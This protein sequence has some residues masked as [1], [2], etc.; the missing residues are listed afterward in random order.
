LRRRVDERHALDVVAEQL[1]ARDAFVLGREDVDDAAADRERSRFGGDVLSEVSELDQTHR[2]LVS[3]DRSAGSKVERLEIGGAR[4]GFVHERSRRRDDDAGAGPVSEQAQRLQAMCGH[5]GVGRQTLVGKDVPRRQQRGR[6]DEL[7]GR[8]PQRLRVGFRGHNDED[9]TLE[10][11]R[12]PGT[13]ERARGVGDGEPVAA[14]VCG[15]AEGRVGVP[16][17][18]EVCQR[19]SHDAP[20]RSGDRAEGAGHE[21]LPQLATALRPRT[22]LSMSRPNAR[23]GPVRKPGPCCCETSLCAFGRGAVSGGGLR[24]RVQPVLR[25][26]DAVGDEGADALQAALH[27]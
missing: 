14:A 22:P 23:K 21:S 7:G 3:I 18:Y 8:G 2:Q 5:T 6:R 17:V 12:E 27:R 13:E 20:F 19:C 11:T 9:A 4:R 25:G 10:A 24:G 16:S 26:V 1:D 15:V